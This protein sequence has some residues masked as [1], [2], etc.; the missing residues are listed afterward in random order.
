MLTITM[1]II[2]IYYTRTGKTEIVAKAIAEEFSCELRKIQEKP[3][4]KGLFGYIRAGYDAIKRK[5]VQLISP[6][7]SLDYDLIFIGTPTWAWRPVPAIITYLQQCNL[8]NKDV[9]LFSTYASSSGNSV[10]IMW[11]V[12]ENKKGRIL[13]SFTV[14]TLGTNEQIIKRTKKHLDKIKEIIDKKKPNLK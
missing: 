11:D 1:K 2:V 14:Q 12:V 9:I 6:N 5:T 8:E 10:K 7:F 4:R 13:Y 3:N